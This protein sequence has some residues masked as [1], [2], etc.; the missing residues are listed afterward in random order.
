MA[1]V[2]RENDG[3]LPELREDCVDGGVYVEPS[4]LPP[5]VTSPDERQVSEH[6]PDMA[7]VPPGKAPLPPI[8]PVLAECDADLPPYAPPADEGAKKTEEANPS[9]SPEAPR[10]YRRKR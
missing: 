6:A 1:K 7:P 8:V 10:Q 3:T 5:S 9:K 2:G 4:V